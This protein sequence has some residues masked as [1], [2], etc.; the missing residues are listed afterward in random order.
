M[1]KK[2]LSGLLILVTVFTLCTVFAGASDYGL[3][4]LPNKY[5]S[6]SIAKNENLLLVGYN[7]N[8]QQDYIKILQAAGNLSEMTVCTFRLPENHEGTWK[9]FVLN[10][11]WQPVFHVADLQEPPIVTPRI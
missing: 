8:G 6:I 11:S 2:I 9:L 4:P 3:T 5:Y 1:K 10:K 7:A